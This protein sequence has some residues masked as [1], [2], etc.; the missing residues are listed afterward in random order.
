[1]KYISAMLLFFF[2]SMSMN[3]QG[4]PESF[5]NGKA[6]VMISAAPQARPPMNWTDIAENVHPGLVAAGGDPVAYYELEDVALSEET[7]AGY[8]EAFN[9]RQVKS[10]VLLTRKPNGEIALTI[11]PYTNNKNIVSNAAEF[12]LQMPDAASMKESLEALGKNI[13]SKNMLVLDVPEYP[14]PEGT[15]PTS[16]RRFLKRNP[17]NLDVFKLGIPLSGTVG[18]AGFLTM[19]RYDLLGKSAEAIAAEQVAEKRGMEGIL[20]ANYSHQV[21]FLTEAKPEAE[22]IRDRV[23]FLLMRVEGREADLMESMGLEVTDPSSSTRIVVKYYIKFLVRNELYI[24]PDWD[25]DPNWQKALGQF[26]ENL[27]KQ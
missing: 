24:G 13:R 11:T 5:L 2:M 14:T 3:G 22:L 18:E 25:A 12:S 4:L 20:K 16:Q 19:Y 17:L 23:Q 15:V 8:A 1:M 27:K 26:L 10:I 6:V 21:A 9:K 7:Q